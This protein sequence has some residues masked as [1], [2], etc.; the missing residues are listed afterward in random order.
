MVAGGMM[1]LLTHTK[2]TRKKNNTIIQ[3]L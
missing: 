1:I 2:A 3:D